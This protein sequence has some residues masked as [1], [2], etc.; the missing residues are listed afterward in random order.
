MLDARFFAGCFRE[1]IGGNAAV[2]TSK[3]GS[4]RSF[5]EII[6]YRA[7]GFGVMGVSG[8]YPKSVPLEREIYAVL[9]LCEEKGVE[10]RWR[11]R[12]IDTN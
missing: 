6:S 2:A 4:L 3:L 1:A 10:T 5:L 7:W 9:H 8:E 11:Y 12:N